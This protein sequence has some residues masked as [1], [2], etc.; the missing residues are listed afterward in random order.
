MRCKLSVF[1]VAAITTPLLGAGASHWT[2][3]N[4]ADFKR[5]KFENVV[6]TSLG[7]LKLSRAVKTL[8]RQDP[9]VTSVY[10]LVEAPDG[11]VY[12]GTGP[13]GIILQVQ[14]EKVSTLATLEDENVFSMLI[15]A[16]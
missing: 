1:L 11:T 3:T 8:P 16:D 4:E 14:G 7:C 15:D 6:A 13:Q 2:H 12:A 10:C 5:R 9:R